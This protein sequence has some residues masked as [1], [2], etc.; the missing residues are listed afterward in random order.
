MAV[1]QMRCARPTSRVPVPVHVLQVFNKPR[2]I[3]TLVCSSC[4][5]APSADWIHAITFH[6]PITTGIAGQHLAL[7]ASALSAGRTLVVWRIIARIRFGTSCRHGARFKQLG[8]SWAC[9]VDV[10]RLGSGQGGHHDGGKEMRRSS[11]SSCVGRLG[12]ASCDVSASGFQ[13]TNGSY[14]VYCASLPYPRVYA[15]H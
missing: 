2:I 14:A 11:P 8:E 4:L 10:G 9:F 1:L 15:A 7:L 6:L 3:S 13:D 12:T 5:L